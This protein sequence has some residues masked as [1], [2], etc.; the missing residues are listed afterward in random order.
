MT[1][2][3]IILYSVF[4]NASITLTLWNKDAEQFDEDNSHPTL[5]L[6][7]ASVGE[8]YNGSKQLTSVY[9]IVVQKNPNTPKGHHLRHWY[10][11]E[12]NGG[13]V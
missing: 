9:G 13:G 4:R 10:N 7:G 1:F 6:I 12:Y 8:F 2:V 3:N 11:N 5:M